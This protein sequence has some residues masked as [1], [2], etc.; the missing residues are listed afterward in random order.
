MRISGLTQLCIFELSFTCLFICLIACALLLFIYPLAFFVYLLFQL[1]H[2]WVHSGQMH[3]HHSKSNAEHNHIRCGI[4]LPWY[5][6]CSCTPWRMTRYNKTSY[7]R[8]AKPAASR[9]ENRISP[10]LFDYFFTSRCLNATNYNPTD[11]SKM[12]R[13]YTEIKSRYIDRPRFWLTDVD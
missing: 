4:K 9:A 12:H 13:T 10:C 3:V 8:A 5:P 1:T 2:P 6:W 7:I 11:F